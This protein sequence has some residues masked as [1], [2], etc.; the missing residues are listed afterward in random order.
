M[1]KVIAMLLTL[2]MAVSFCIPSFASGFDPS[3]IPGMITGVIDTVKQAV[4]GV[5]AEVEATIAAVPA[6]PQTDDEAA[7]KEFELGCEKWVNA[8]L[9]FTADLDESGEPKV[10]ENGNIVY[11]P[12]PNAEP[13]KVFTRESLSAAVQLLVNQGKL[14]VEQQAGIEKAI[15]KATPPANAGIKLP[16]NVVALIL[17]DTAQELVDALTAN[18]IPLNAMK[19]ALKALVAA[20]VVRNDEQLLNDTYALIDELSKK[21][22]EANKGEGGLKDKISGVINTIKDKLG[23]G[24]GSGDD[25]SNSEAGMKDPTGDVAIYSVLGVAA[26]AGAALVLTRKKKEN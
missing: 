2:V 11:I 20:K 26:V 24:G 7:V 10:D 12:D 16:E 4:Q 6:A 5:V 18:K 17:A 15:K 23:L 21:D 14:T 19:A 22:A 3:Q 8:R 13:T 25:A 9:G 1:K